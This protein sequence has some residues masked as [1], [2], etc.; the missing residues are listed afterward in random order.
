MLN[1]RRFSAREALELGLLHKV[2]PDDK[3][4]DAVEKEVKAVMRCAPEAVSASK[5]LIAAVEGRPPEEVLRE[6][7][8]RLARTWETESCRQGIAAFLEKR[9]PPWISE[10]K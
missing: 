7:I 8:D 2:V 10:K 1:A 9:K 4:D 3:L 6:T 5:E